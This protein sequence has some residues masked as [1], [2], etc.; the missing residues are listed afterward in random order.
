M[1]KKSVRHRILISNVCMVLVTLLLFLSINTLIIFC[2]S[3]SVEDE[4]KASVEKVVEPSD[5]EELLKDYTIYRNEFILLFIVDGILCI[6]ALLIVS[7][8]FTRNLTQHIMEPLEALAEGTKRIKNNN[9]EQKIIYS[10]DKE[11][12]EVCS[13]FNDMM[14][15]VS[16]EQEKNRRYEKA[17]TDMIAGISHDLRTPL[18]AVKGTIKGLLDGVAVKPEQQQKFLETAY[19]RTG[20]MDMLLNQLFYLSKIET[21]NMPVCLQNIDIAEFLKAYVNTRR[22][23]SKDENWIININ[24]DAEED[25]GEIQA[26]SVQLERIFDNLIDNSRKYADS[27][28]LII[29]FLLYREQEKCCICIKDNGRGVP[30]DKIP[31]I[32]EEFYR[33]DESRNKKEGSGLGL[34][35]VKCLME[36]M[37]GSVSAVNNDGFAVYLR[38]P[39]SDQKGEDNAGEKDN[40]YC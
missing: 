35:I 11:F 15:A 36:K 22:Y 32:F 16:T 24:I 29:D 30:E 10:G 4:V 39:V 13:S 18:T 19:R 27:Q 8:Y 7:Q 26:D 2:Y 3:E 20:D 14:K 9:L 38:F 25:I 6:A 23:Y 12:E 1:E 5:I 37:K 33:A 31:H 40:P 17:R 34:Y 21:G 28:P